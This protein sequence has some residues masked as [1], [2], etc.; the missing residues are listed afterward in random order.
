MAQVKLFSMT[1]VLTLLIWASADSLVNEAATV[2]VAFELTPG[3][4]DM[5]V[6]PAEALA[7]FDL[8]I[9]GPRSDIKDL[10]DQAPLRVRLRIPD[11][12]TGPADLPLDRRYLKQQLAEQYREF[13]KLAV[14]SVHPDT[15][16]VQ[17]DHWT[18]RR[19]DLDLRRTT[20]SYE[21]EPQLDRTSVTV[22]MRESGPLS[23]PG[24]D[25]LRIDISGEVE[26]LLKG[27]PQGENLRIPL[28]LDASRFGRGATLDP[29]IVHVSATLKAQ[30]RLVEIPTVPILLAVSF[31]NLEQPLRPVTRDGTPLTLV[32]PSI[33]VTGPIEDVAR[34]ERRTTRA[35]GIIRLKQDDLDDLGA[36]KLI[37]PEYHLPPNITLAADPPPIEFKLIKAVSTATPG[38]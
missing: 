1:A 12:P 24:T 29:G 37:T 36:I 17:V 15:L 6:E 21:V 5:L 4:A 16:P 22:R 10:L 8:Q 28:T 7:L 20:L 3:A 38:G 23:Q 11:R 31:A 18:T 25:A 9:S 30:R 19:I 26:R 27:Q 35:F 13:R 34:L 2:A 32:A 14:V 33:T